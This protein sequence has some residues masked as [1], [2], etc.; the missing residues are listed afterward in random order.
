MT[1]WAQF[2]QVKSVNTD[3]LHSWEVPKS[4]ANS[5]VFIVYDERSLSHHSPA[6]S[7]FTLCEKENQGSLFFKIMK[8]FKI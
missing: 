8:L 5:M 4:I 6:V 3:E 1:T 7:K 2:Q